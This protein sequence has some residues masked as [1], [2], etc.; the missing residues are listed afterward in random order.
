MTIFPIFLFSLRVLWN[1]PGLWKF[2]C[3][4]IRWLNWF[5]YFSLSH[6]NILSRLESEHFSRSESS[7]FLVEI[8]NVASKKRSL[9]QKH[10]KKSKKLCA[11]RARNGA[12]EFYACYRASVDIFWYVISVGVRPIQEINKCIRLSGL[13]ECLIRKQKGKW[14]SAEK[15]S[16][17]RRL[18]DPIL[19]NIMLLCIH[20]FIITLIRQSHFTRRCMRIG[21][22]LWVRHSTFL[23]FSDS[24]ALRLSRPPPSLS[25][26]TP[27]EGSMGI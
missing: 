5:C 21:D 10:K 14:T 16:M 15:K 1:A 6:Q 26:Y 25:P 7:E 17:K 24:S 11:H 18:D 22:K 8:R 4:E 3:I 12:I 27:I 9:F 19:K 20:T 2:L 13:N 23:S